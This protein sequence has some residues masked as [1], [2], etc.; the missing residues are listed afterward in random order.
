[1]SLLKTFAVALNCTETRN[2]IYSQCW[3]SE[4]MSLRLPCFWPT[5]WSP[6]STRTGVSLQAVNLLDSNNLLTWFPFFLIVTSLSSNNKHSECSCNSLFLLTTHDCCLED[7][8]CNLSCLVSSE[9]INSML[10]DSSLSPQDEPST[11]FIKVVD[12]F[13]GGSLKGSSNCCL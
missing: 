4:S 1:M 2:L 5:C 13:I 12:P 10:S 7:L 3:G 9:I 11:G 6:C 8:M